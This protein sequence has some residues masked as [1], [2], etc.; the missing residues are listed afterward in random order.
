MYRDFNSFPLNVNFFLEKKKGIYF[1][2]CNQ[3]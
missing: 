2:V 3:L 1:Y